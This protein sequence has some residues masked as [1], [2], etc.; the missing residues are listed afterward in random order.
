MSDP[1]DLKLAANLARWRESGQPQLWCDA[2]QG[3]WDQNDWLL[4]LSSLWWSDY[5][6]MDP[7]AVAAVLADCKVPW[8]L[9]RW[10]A[11]GLAWKWV[12]VHGGHWDHADWL[13]LLDTLR[14]S[15]FWP[16]EPDALGGVLEEVR[17]AWQSL[18]R[19]KASGLPQRW[20]DAHQ[21]VW[22]HADWL[23]L[24]DELENSEFWPLDLNAVGRLLEE[25]KVAYHNLVRWQLTGHPR[26]WVA[27]QQGQWGEDGWNELLRTLRGSDFWP[28]DMTG[29][30]RL[31][32]GLRREWWNLRRWRDSGL[33]GRWMAA[34][35]G[36][37]D[38]NDWLG[39]L[40]SLELSGFWP[41]DPAA[42]GRALEEVRHE[43]LNLR[44]WHEAGEP[45]R[46]LA[47]HPDRPVPLEAL[48]QSGYWPLDPRAAQ[49]LVGE[50]ARSRE[51]LRRWQESGHARRWVAVHGGAWNHAD[52]LSLLAELQASEYGPLSP[53]EVGAVLEREKQRYA[54][55]PGP[56]AAVVQYP[57]PTQRRA[58]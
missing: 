11:S 50:L 2:H 54:A 43:W 58:A 13:A 40:A 9:R 3:H 53:E 57:P 12:D 42:L 24:V 31:L 7:D 52:W 48:Q 36:R 45:Q 1:I 46:W 16:V 41:I 34:R 39:L 30:T 25:L 5:W 47:A 28:L 18:E 27:Q 29:I 15:E 20:V 21:G 10:Q 49:A 23:G 8:N 37:W 38:H 55:P 26:R 17:A 6:P 51:N 4:L 56:E 22:D 33:A 32:E 19:W 44:R 35:Q 14:A